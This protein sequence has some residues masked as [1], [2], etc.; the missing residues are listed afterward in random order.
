MT[1]EYIVI[2]PMTDEA[3]A[4]KRRILCQAIAA[5]YSNEEGETVLVLMSGEPS[6]I[7]DSPESIDAQLERY[8]PEPIPDYR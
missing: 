1:A 7:L 6:K 5:Y 2:T 3:D 8:F 4:P